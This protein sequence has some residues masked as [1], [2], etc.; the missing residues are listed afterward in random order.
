MF[1]TK[2]IIAIAILVW[3]ICLLFLLWCWR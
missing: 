3:I 2:N 1:E